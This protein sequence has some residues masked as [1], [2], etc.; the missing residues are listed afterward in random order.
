MSKYKANTY[1]ES[2]NFK[3]S[4]N[5]GL[6][7]YAICNNLLIKWVKTKFCSWCVCA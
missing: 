6:M 5:L 3:P 4:Y 7:K 2:R 1:Y